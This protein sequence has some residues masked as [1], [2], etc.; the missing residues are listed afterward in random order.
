MRRLDHPR[1]VG[2]AHL[3]R[4]ER[5]TKLLYIAGAT[6]SGSTL[7]G[8]ILGQIEGFHFLGEVMHAWRGLRD[9][10]CGCNTPVQDCDFWAAV[11]RKLGGEDRPI[12]GPELFGAGQLARWRYMPQTLAPRPRLASRF[13]AQWRSRERLYEAVAAVSGARVVVDS[14]K[15]PV[16]GRMLSLLP[17]LDLHVVHLVRDARAVAHSWNRLKPTPQVAGRPY[18]RRHPA[19]VVAIRWMI[20]NLGAELFCRRVPDRYLRLRYE[21]LIARPREAIEGILASIAEARLDLPFREERMVALSP[22]HSV[23]GNPDRFKTGL[24]D[25][26][27]D[28]EWERAMRPRDRRVVTTLT[29]PL[30]L[31]H[32]YVNAPFLSAGRHRVA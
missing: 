9:R 11:R 20:S 12:A 15:S 13:R 8:Q 22:T 4:E 18:M 16:Y 3:G 28:D 1:Q 2:Y 25:L 31:R 29:W 6:R 30:L 19:A 5:T 26:R 7:L 32:G 24:I 10:P 17:A 21:D 27:L 14:S 23:W